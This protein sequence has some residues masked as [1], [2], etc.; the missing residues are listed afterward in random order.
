MLILKTVC[1]NVCISECIE[2][3][4]R[5]LHLTIYL[6]SMVDMRKIRDPTSVV[7]GAEPRGK[8]WKDIN[9]LRNGARNVES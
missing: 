1:R 6:E 9:G 2:K 3:G 4:N 8:S 7:V 5:N